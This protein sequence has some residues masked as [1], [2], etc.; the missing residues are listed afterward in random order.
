[1]E[2]EKKRRDGQTLLEGVSR[3]A[4]ACAFLINGDSTN[5]IGRLKS[6][7]QHTG[8]PPIRL[9]GCDIKITLMSEEEKSSAS[10]ESNSATFPATKRPRPSP[11]SDTTTTNATIATGLFETTHRIAKCR[12]YA[13]HYLGKVCSIPGFS[14]RH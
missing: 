9:Q 4:S 3:Y 6:Q 11:P 8:T 12:L 1:M 5:T 13:S 14:R 2:Y 10:T 7:K